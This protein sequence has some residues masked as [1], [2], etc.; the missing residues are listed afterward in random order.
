M[1]CQVGEAGFG[2]QLEHSI[3]CNYI[4]A[5]LDA[6][7]ILDGFHPSAHHR[8]GGE[9][10]EAAALLGLT[11]R[12]TESGARSY[13]SNPPLSATQFIS[14]PDAEALN[15]EVRRGKKNHSCFVMYASDIRSCGADAWCDMRQVFDNFQ[16]TYHKLRNND[17]RQGCFERGLGFL[18]RAPLPE[19]VQISWHIRTGDVCLHCND[20]D[21]WKRIY[22]QLLSVPTIAHSHTITFESQFRAEWL[23]AEPMFANASYSHSNQTLLASICRF[24]TA[25]VLITT[26]SSLAPFVAA[27]LPPL[28][29]VVLE[30]RRKEAQN[31]GES[32]WAHHFFKPWESF[33]MEDGQIQMALDNF[34]MQVDSVLRDRLLDEI[35]YGGQ[36]A[37]IGGS[38]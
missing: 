16:L 35:V 4:A 31:V 17:A 30:E 5:L 3:F 36:C 14:A 15:R 37:G 12:L 29:P 18:S 28:A 38:S 24:I 20:I 32:R 10:L 2:D 27:F 7:A 33:H 6:D 13:F 23:E 1:S 34:I 25:D 11:S 21:Y 9:Y 22:S 19:T 8:G 26:G